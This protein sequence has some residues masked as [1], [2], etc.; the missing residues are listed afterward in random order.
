VRRRL[1]RAACRQSNSTWGRRQLVN[2]QPTRAAGTTHAPRIGSCVLPGL[3]TF[4][5]IGRLASAT[6]GVL[7]S[8]LLDRLVQQSVGLRAQPLGFF[9]IVDGRQGTLPSNADMEPLRTVSSAARAIASARCHSANRA[10]NDFDSGIA[11]IVARRRRRCDLLR[12]CPTWQFCVRHEIGSASGPREFGLLRAAEGRPP[13][14]DRRR[15][16]ERLCCRTMSRHR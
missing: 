15:L 16:I 14:G 10:L 2:A 8:H 11:Q 13:Q 7:F 5:A 12:A 6:A 9:P 3:I 4:C 1:D